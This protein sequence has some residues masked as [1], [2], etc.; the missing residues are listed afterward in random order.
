MQ[1]L[2]LSSRTKT[3][4]RQVHVNMLRETLSEAGKR[5][6]G[7]SFRIGVATTVVARG[8][9]ETT[10]Q[11]LRHRASVS[12]RKYIRIPRD[13]LAQMSRTLAQI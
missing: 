10:I 11:T 1:D 12:F 9:S 13:Q 2:C 8:H 7:H 3:L 4:T 6:S 5:F